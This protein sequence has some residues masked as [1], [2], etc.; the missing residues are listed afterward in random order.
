MILNLAVFR[1]D[2]MISF[3]LN[4]QITWS[5]FYWTTGSRDPVHKFKYFK[6][7]EAILF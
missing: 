3:S 7:W 5:L 1:L 6:F 4:N 2:H